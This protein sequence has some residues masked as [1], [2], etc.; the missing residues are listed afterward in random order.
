MTDDGVVQQIACALIEQHGA[1]RAI[2]VTER[3]ALSTSGGGVEF[4]FRV[5]DAVCERIRSDG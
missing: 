3:L 2:A 1:T 4:W 5:L